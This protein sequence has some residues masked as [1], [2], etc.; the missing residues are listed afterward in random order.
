MKNSFI[1]L[2]GAGKKTLPKASFESDSEAYVG[3]KRLRSR[4]HALK[5][6]VQAVVTK[7][8]KKY[9]FDGVI[10]CRRVCKTHT[11]DKCSYNQNLF[12]YF[13]L[14]HQL[15]NRDW[16]GMFQLLSVYGDISVKF[17]VEHFCCKYELCEDVS[18]KLCFCYK[19]D[20]RKGKALK[21]VRLTS[22]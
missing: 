3:N 22:G 16:R 21:W 10:Y 15:K 19:N 11:Q 17:A 6:M 5:I 14:T 7:P 1:Q 20:N 13:E 4:C 12:K 8:I 9:D 18:K 2:C